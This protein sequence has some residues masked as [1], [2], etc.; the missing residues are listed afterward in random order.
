MN[1]IEKC[2]SFF[3][4]SRKEAQGFVILQIIVCL[5]L[6]TPFIADA[7]VSPLPM[8]AA[9]NQTPLD[10]L[11]RLLEA[12]STGAHTTGTPP[13]VQAS[14]KFSEKIDPNTVDRE[15]L[16]KAGLTTKVVDRII[17][18]REKGGKFWNKN[19][20]LKIYGLDKS[21]FGKIEPY[22]IFPS[23]DKLTKTKSPSV[24]DIN[25]ADS[26]M[27]E[28]LSGIGPT[29]AGRILNYRNALGGFVSKEQFSEVYG[30]TEK[31]LIQLKS[32][33]IIDQAFEPVKIN[34][35]KADFKS[36]ARHPYMGYQAARCIDRLR[37]KDI[38][39]ELI[40]SL[41]H[42][43]SVF[44]CRNPRLLIRYIEMDE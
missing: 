30:L 18:Y 3:G 2:K 40:Q 21:E 25:K 43:D 29:L 1:L 6:L 24:F 15:V 5:V 39:A 14:A 26:A 13:S 8:D 7:L 4:I 16:L 19:D 9:A 33:T 42:S 22:L 35:Q 38:S 12:S 11:V 23:A 27:L 31:A 41:V 17:K 32:L 37:K 10:S 36:I 20:V 34:L 44:K 28:G